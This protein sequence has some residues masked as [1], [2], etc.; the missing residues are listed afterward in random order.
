MRCVSAFISTKIARCNSYALW[1]TLCNSYALWMTLCN[2]YA[3][4]VHGDCE[5]NL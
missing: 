4:H 3:L 5:A 1:M 2:S